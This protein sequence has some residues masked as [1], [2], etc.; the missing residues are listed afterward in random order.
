MLRSAR[1]RSPFL[2]GVKNVVFC[3]QRSVARISA[4]GAAP[5]GREGVGRDSIVKLGESPAAGFWKSLAV[6]FDEK[7]ILQSVRHIHGKRSLRTL[8]WL[9][10]NFRDLGAVGETLAVAGNAGL[11]GG[12]HGGVGDDD[13]E[14]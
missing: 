13:F 7:K 4:G 2:V 12:D 3:R 1:R 14:H 9:P 5:V 11:V 6:L 8:L 10:L